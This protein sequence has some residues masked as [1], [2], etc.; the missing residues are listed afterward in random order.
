MN[1]LVVQVSIWIMRLEIW[2]I[3]FLSSSLEIKYFWKEKMEI[4]IG[5]ENIAMPEANSVVFSFFLLFRI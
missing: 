5:G 3:L 2:L 4:K 1:L